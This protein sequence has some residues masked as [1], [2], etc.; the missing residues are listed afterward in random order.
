MATSSLRPIVSDDEKAFWY[1]CQSSAEPDATFTAATETFESGVPLLVGC[2]V[3]GTVVRF[4]S[5]ADGSAIREITFAVDGDVVP[6]TPTEN[7]SVISITAVNGAVVSIVRR[8]DA[9]TVGRG[10]SN[11]PAI[12]TFT[13]TTVLSNTSLTGTGYALCIGGGGGGGGSVRQNGNNRG[14]SGGGGGSGGAAVGIVTTLQNQTVTIGAAG[15]GAA[16]LTT[17]ANGANQQ[18]AAGNAGGATSVGSVSAAGGSGGGGGNL[19]N[20]GQNG[21]GGSG[22]SGGSPRGAAGGTGVGTGNLALNANQWLGNV[23]AVSTPPGSASA[24]FANAT[25]SSGGGGSLGNNA[26]ATVLAPAANLG[27]GGY[28]NDARNDVV[29]AATGY[30]SGG[31]GGNMNISVGNSVA[32]GAG[33]PGI[34][35][36]F[37]IA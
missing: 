18:A 31:Q 2:T 7:V 24:V 10:L 4:M 19:N 32:A 17:N 15:N 30:G 28:T 8:P 21:T 16:N 1:L 25:T 35:Y 36:I 11:N 33:R 22:G 27:R 13:S 12:S 20:G 23:G 29:V 37:R 3:A 14:A 26:G 5:S 9:E 6:Y 34:A